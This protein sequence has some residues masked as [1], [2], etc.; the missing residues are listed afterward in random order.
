MD[1]SALVDYLLR[2]PRGE[3][4]APSIEDRDA[5]LNTPA[6][7]DVEVVAGLRRA[8]LSGLISEQRALQAIEDHLDLPLT[9]HGHARLLHRTLA[10]RDNFSAYD[11]TYVALAERVD[12]ELLTS[13]TPFARAV[14][15]HTKIGTLPGDEDD[16]GLRLLRQAPSACARAERRPA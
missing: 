12:A 13:D 5:D 14:R 15:R 4:V 7:C 16:H 10:L 2:T 3:D 8:L 11:A 6:L 1:A 9:R